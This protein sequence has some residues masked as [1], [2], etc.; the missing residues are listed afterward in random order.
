MTEHDYFMAW[1]AYLAAAFGCLLIAFFSTRW[2]WRWLREPLCVVVAVL[3][4]TPSLIEPAHHFYAPSVAVA[5]LGFLFKAGTHLPLAL[6]DLASIGAVAAGLY[7]VFA[8]GRWLFWRSR[9]AVEAKAEPA[10]TT[11]I[12]A[13]RSHHV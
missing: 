8:L 5:A 12:A 3:L 6:M 10:E 4:F 11:E 1:A 13:N 2:M 7:G 9:P